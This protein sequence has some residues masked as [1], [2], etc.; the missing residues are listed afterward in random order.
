MTPTKKTTSEAK[1][2]FDLLM[3]QRLTYGDFITARR[4]ASLRSASVKEKIAYELMKQRRN[5]R[6]DAIRRS[7][8]VLPGGKA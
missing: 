2:P 4:H 6:A 3:E 5:K 7:F 1:L 8:E